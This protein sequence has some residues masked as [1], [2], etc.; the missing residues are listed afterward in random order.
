MYVSAFF[1][2]FNNYGDY[3]ITVYSYPQEIRPGEI[4]HIKDDLWFKF[5][6][7]E[8]NG[9]DVYEFVDMIKEFS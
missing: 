6:I 1:L 7:D 3:Q 9:I 5:D 8:N 2:H 4:E